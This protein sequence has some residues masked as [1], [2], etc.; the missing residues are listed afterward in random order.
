MY[1]K[2]AIIIALILLAIV[3]WLTVHQRT[4][5]Q[6]AYLMKEAIRNRDFTFRLSGKGLLPGEKAMQ[7]SLNEL[8][9]AFM[10]ERNK[11]EVRSWERLIRVLTH[12]IMNTTAPITSISQAMMERDDVK[13]SALEE[14]IRAI[15]AA[16]NHL[17]TFVDSYRKLTQ[18]QSPVLKSTSLSEFMVE[19]TSLYPEIK[20]E[21][22]CKCKD[23]IMT[24]PV[25]LRQVFIN[26]IKN[27][28][29]AN[30]NRMA[31]NIE[32]TEGSDKNQQINIYISN[33]G[34]PIPADTLSTIFVPFFTTKRSGTGIGLSLCQQIMTRLNGDI[35][36]C[37]SPK[38]SYTTTFRLCMPR[39]CKIV[40][41]YYN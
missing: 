27:A 10:A 8:G 9:E 35:M 2:I 38:N 21:T 17:N 20:W 14:G 30:A 25:M 40:H 13:G 31:V 7:Q 24:D 11:N 1:T 28:I 18:L 41:K 6:R 5:K 12:E 4:L 23:G 22:E 19:T 26:I 33:N 36:L 34:T 29:D 16:G 3:V 37:D 32:E 15:N 39:N